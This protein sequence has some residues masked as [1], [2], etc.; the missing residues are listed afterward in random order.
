LI[1]L[2]GEVPCRTLDY[3]KPGLRQ[4]ARTA[5]C[6]RA[7]LRLR[8]LRT[9]LRKA[10]AELGLLGW[11]QADFDPATQRQVDAIHHVE[12]EQANLANRSA[13]MKRSLDA[14][15]AE[16][17]RSTENF[18]RGRGA[19][20]ADLATARAPL[21][22]AERRL[23]ILRDREP[24]M[25]REIGKLEKKDREIALLCERL[26][27]VQ[28]QPPDVQSELLSLRNQTLAISN[29][30][31]D[32]KLQHA[33]TLSDIEERERDRSEARAD[34]DE[35]ER[36][37]RELDA[38]SRKEEERF[39]ATERDLAREKAGI[40]RDINQLDRAKSDPYLEIGRVLADSGIAPMNQPAAL[41]K[42][43]DLRAD[44]IA[45]EE[46]AAR[47]ARQSASQNQTELVISLLL[48]SVIAL[49]MCFVLAAIF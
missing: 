22:E 2:P 30:K 12:R 13:E 18:T 42:V 3:L 11:Q 36:K 47:L 15:Q 16:R 8:G 26:L 25:E 40:D 17:T 45:T 39:A 44:I 28:P 5:K 48:L 21:A 37:L 4:I 32:L 1:S 20:K 19:L 49:A 6:L 38:A 35:I 31:A 24:E 10:E 43:L 27:T 7:H 23:R 46:A 33:R 34:V 41:A 29:E 9:R 14:L